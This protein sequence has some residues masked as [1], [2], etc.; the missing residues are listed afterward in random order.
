MFQLVI[1]ACLAMTT[2]MAVAADTA[3][4]IVVSQAWIRASLGQSPTTAAY[5][6]IENRGLAEDRL[7]AIATPSAAMAQLHESV[8]TGGVVQMR[9][10]KALDVGPGQVVEF[11]PGGMHIMV[12]NVKS[13]LQAGQTVTLILRFERAGVIEVEAEVR[14][15]NQPGPARR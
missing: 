15:L 14:G 7:L 10:V 3:A 8:T 1:L 13:A 4:G 12:M 2:G 11:A 6:R 5:A 9:P